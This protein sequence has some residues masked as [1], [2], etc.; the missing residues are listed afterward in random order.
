VLTGMGRDGTAGC[1]AITRSG[2]RVICQN[3]GTS[4]VFGMPASIVESGI[5]AEVLPLEE[6]AH[7]IVRQMDAL[8][9]IGAHA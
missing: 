4:M 6:I 3:E 8:H 2:G 1:K 5:E 9:K 7:G